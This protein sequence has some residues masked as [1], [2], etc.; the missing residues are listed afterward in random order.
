MSKQS[1]RNS[2]ADPSQLAA[3]RP[4]INRISRRIQL[5][6]ND[7]SADELGLKSLGESIKIATSATVDGA[8][9]FLSRIYLPTAEEFGLLLRDKVQAYRAANAVAMD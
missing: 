1:A 8:A 9:A 6:D 2:A 3:V 5:S 4:Y 7:N